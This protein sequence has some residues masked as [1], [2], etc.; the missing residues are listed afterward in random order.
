MLG[1]AKDQMD[2]NLG[3]FGD[4]MGDREAWCAA[5]HGL[6]KSQTLPGNWTTKIKYKH[7]INA[8]EFSNTWISANATIHDLDGPFCCYR[9]YWHCGITTFSYIQVNVFLFLSFFYF[10]YL[11][12]FSG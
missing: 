4:M 8:E 3:K 1:Y 6:A 2:M 9:K 11:F 7:D 12:I 5:V 10:I